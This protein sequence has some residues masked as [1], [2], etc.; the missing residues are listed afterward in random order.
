[1]EKY[2][3]EKTPCLDTFHAVSILE[4]ILK[5]NKSLNKQAYS[6]NVKILISLFKNIRDSAI[7]LIL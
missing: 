5:R 4:S 2:E 1:M 6:K 3:P 7:I